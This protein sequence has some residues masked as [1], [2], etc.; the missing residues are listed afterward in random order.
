[1]AFG[2]PNSGYVPPN[3]ER[4]DTDYITGQTL[5]GFD[6]PQTAFD[7][8][9]R[10]RGINPYVANPFTQTMRSRLARPV[11]QA[12][13][14]QRATQGGGQ[15]NPPSMGSPDPYDYRTYL[16]NLLN[17]QGGGL[18]GTIR[19]QALNMPQ[20]IQQ[21]RAYQA[22]QNASGNVQNVN[23]FMEALGQQFGADNG[24]GAASAQAALYSPL[25]AQPL[26]QA[27]RTGVQQT[28]SNALYQMMN[29]PNPNLNDDLWKW[30]YG[31]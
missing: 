11:A 9:L 25:M 6:D 3:G 5:Y 17:D 29:Q 27:Y 12:Y 30:L 13:L 10:D 2:S 19:T 21:L 7:S 26:S 8:V 18:Y 22:A 23:P 24:M 15:T 1:M 28:A 4:N 16:N 20:T 14:M 31:V